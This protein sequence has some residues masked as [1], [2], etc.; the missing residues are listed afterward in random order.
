MPLGV[1]VT[2][3]SLQTFG[4]VGVAWAQ[5]VNAVIMVSITMIVLKVAMAR[6]AHF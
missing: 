6:D 5:V 3:S 2:Y 4:I 1:A